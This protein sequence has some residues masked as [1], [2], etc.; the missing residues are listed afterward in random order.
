METIAPEKP[1]TAA[2]GAENRD[3][4]FIVDKTDNYT[5]EISVN[6][7]DATDRVA[8]ELKTVAGGLEVRPSRS[9]LDLKDPDE[10]I[11]VTKEVRDA[12]GKDMA[13][14]EIIIS[15]AYNNEYDIEESSA[16]GKGQTI[17]L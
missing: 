3:I 14:D 4:E 16:K 12:I 8:A 1:Q 7:K 13:N 17:E 6:E 9:R 11:I 15:P 10:P 5:G 2:L